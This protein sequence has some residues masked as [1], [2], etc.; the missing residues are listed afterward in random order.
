M[1]RDIIELKDGL[2]ER[3]IYEIKAICQYFHN[4]NAGKVEIREITPT[5]FVFEGEKKDWQTLVI[6]Y[7]RLAET[8]R[9][10]QNV[11]RWDWEDPHP[12]ECCDML[13]VLKLTSKR[14]V[15]FV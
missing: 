4:N 15:T 8:S 9:F 3:E 14:T 1:Y 7:L 13:R 2:T 5:H 10:W 11:K 6:G 12:N